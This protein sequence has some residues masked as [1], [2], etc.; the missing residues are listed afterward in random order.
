VAAKLEVELFGARAALVGKRRAGRLKVGRLV[1]RSAASGRL[2]FAVAL[3]PAA[4]RC[5]QRRGALPLI[6]K[7]SVTAR[8]LD[9]FERSRRVVIRKPSRRKGAG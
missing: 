8:G 7:V 3:R 5:L 9:A 2:G 4:R 6:A 1:R